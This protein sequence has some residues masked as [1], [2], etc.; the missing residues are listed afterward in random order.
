MAKYAKVGHFQES[1]MSLNISLPA[2]LESRVRQHVASGMY[3]S[4]SEVIREAL[5]MFEAYQSARTSGLAALQADIAQG[6]ADVGAGRVASL[7]IEDIKRQ[8]RAALTTRKSA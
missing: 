1:T 6:V 5:R 4:A 2:E 7:D 3:G 8:G